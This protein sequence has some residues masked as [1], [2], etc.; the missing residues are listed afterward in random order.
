MPSQYTTLG[1]FKGDINLLST[2]LC[3]MPVVG[4]SRIGLCKYLD[5]SLVGW[6]KD[7]ENDL[8]CDGPREKPWAIRNIEKDHRNDCE[9]QLQKIVE[10]RLNQ[11]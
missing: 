8:G 3:V 10:E 4:F 7:L 6:P 11:D 1:S 2:N 9:A 5:H